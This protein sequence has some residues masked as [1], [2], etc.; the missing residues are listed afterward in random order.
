MFRRIAILLSAFLIIS[1]TPLTAAPVTPLTIV[2]AIPMDQDIA[3]MLV[4]DS[5]IYLF[6]NTPTGGY[7]TALNKDG[8]EKWLHSFSDQRAFTISTGTLDASGNIWLAGASAA[9]IAIPG[10]VIPSPTAAN[11]D[12]VIVGDEGAIRP[13]LNNLTLWKVSSAGSGA[14][15]YELPLTAPVL[16]TSLSVNKSGISIVAWQSAGSLFVSADLLGKFGK[17]LRVGKT[18]TTLDKV[19]RNSDGSSILLGSSTELFLRNKAIGA[20]DGVIIKVDATPKIV[21]SVRSGEKGSTRNWASATS[22]LLLGGYLKSKTTSLATI[23]K[24]GTT[25]KPTWTVRYKATSSAV[26]AN[27]ANFIT[28]AAY[29]NKGSG[30]LVTFDKNGKV[31]ATN[32]FLGQPIAVEFNKSFGLYIYAG[33]SIYNLASQY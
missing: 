1:T 28:Y 11:P 8:S 23:T 2:K 33:D 10:A 24:F 7:V 4:G 13:D 12:G 20:R 22:S 32:P 9:P 5:A 29:E 15:R 26:V 14:G 17:P 19:I 3:G 16:P 6:G 18:S 21:Q 27:G 25:L 30:T 31:K